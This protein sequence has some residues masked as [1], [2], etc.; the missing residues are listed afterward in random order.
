MRV[1][2]GFEQQPVMSERTVYAVASGKG[3]VGKT[4]TAINLGA[5]LAESGHEVVIVDT[6][7]GMAN[8]ADFLE[9]EI[10]DPTLHEVLAGE[11]RVED[12]VRE[13]PGGIDVLPSGIDIEA[14]ARSDSSNLGAVVETLRESY[15]YV[16]LDTGAGVSY[17]TVVPLSVADEVLL[18]ATPDVASVRDT[19]KT[20]ELTERVGGTVAGSV[21]TQRSNDILNADDVGGTLDTDVLAVVPR[22]EA[23]PMGIDAG[24]PL[25]VFAPNSPAA[26]A[27]Q[28]LAA[29]LASEEPPDANPR[30]GDRTPADGPTDGPDAEPVADPFSE[31]ANADGPPSEGSD[32]R[33]P[34]TDEATSESDPLAGFPKEFAEDVPPE[35][36]AFDAETGSDDPSREYHATSADGSDEGGERADGSDSVHDLIDERIVERNAA[37]TDAT[38][39]GSDEP[40]DA[41][42]IP[43]DDGSLGEDGG[44]SEVTDGA[45]GASEPTDEGDGAEE[46]PDDGSHDAGE[47]FDE[48]GETGLF[49]R[50]GSLFR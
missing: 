4:T 26:V 12:A 38:G 36:D 34:P 13:A 19:A 28:T 16:L 32:G 31:A 2:G 43:F 39:G 15:D 25:A 49:G 3:G 48:D 6:D 45:D 18:V 11:A 27:Y 7:L 1:V 40:D 37:E 23:V 17:D 44:T 30:V 50:I 47:S 14:F 10:S 33:S 35:N 41:Q 9:C 29:V 42:A 20:G 5:M 8:L 22:D 21:L 46:A 24:R